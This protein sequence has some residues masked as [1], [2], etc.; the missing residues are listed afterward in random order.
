MLAFILSILFAAIET[1]LLFLLVPAISSGKKGFSALLI[2]LITI[3]LLL[4][5]GLFVFKFLKYFIWCICGFVLGV[6]LSAVIIYIFK[7]LNFNR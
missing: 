4:V 2:S 7:Y 1:Y 3:S 6:P 5:I